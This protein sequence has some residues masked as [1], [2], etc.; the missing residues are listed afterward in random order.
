MKHLAR[1]LRISAFALLAVASSTGHAHDSPCG[2]P[3]AQSRAECD[4]AELWRIEKLSDPERLDRLDSFR[5][6]YHELAGS[7]AWGKGVP[8]G[9]WP[10][11]LLRDPG[12]IVN[13]PKISASLISE[14]KRAVY[15]GH[16]GYILSV[17][18][19]NIVATSATN[20]W[21]PRLDGYSRATFSTLEALSRVATSEIQ[22]P[23]AI[24]AASDPRQFNESIFVGRSWKSRVEVRAVGMILRCSTKEMKRLDKL[25]EAEFSAYVASNCFHGR[26]PHLIPLIAALRG[27]FPIYAYGLR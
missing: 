8:E 22:S 18:P 26:N 6:V 4:N 17:Q 23:E 27:R 25:P 14:T 20:L 3:Y 5:V 13:N 1:S 24:L 15:F 16:F 12:L 9:S 10:V 21:S 19:E 7:G 2:L 11:R